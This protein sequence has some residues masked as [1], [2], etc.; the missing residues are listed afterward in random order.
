M[1]PTKDNQEAADEYRR[2]VRNGTSCFKSFIKN[3][4]FLFKFGAIN[5]GHTI[6]VKLDYYVPLTRCAARSDD[7][8]LRLPLS[9]KPGYS[10]N[11]GENIPNSAQS[12][13]GCKLTVELSSNFDR[14]IDLR[15]GQLFVRNNDQEF[16]LECEVELFINLKFIPK[17]ESIWNSNTV[18]DIT[19]DAIMFQL[20][21]EVLSRTSNL[22]N[23]VAI[24]LDRKVKV[25]YE[26]MACE[27][28][29]VIDMTISMSKLAKKQICKA[30]VA[31]LRRLLEIENDFIVKIVCLGQTMNMTKDWGQ[32][33]KFDAKL[34]EEAEVWLEEKMVLNYGR[35]AELDTILRHLYQ[36][37][38]APL[39]SVP[40]PRQVILMTNSA[41][42]NYDEELQTVRNGR[43]ADIFHNRT[44]AIGVDKNVSMVCL[45]SRSD[46]LISL[47][48][49][50][51][52]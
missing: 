33:R 37:E 14:V 40:L 12:R 49:L 50:G 36:T 23:K 10:L 24:V 8:V 34:L 46:L 16:V 7:F 9:F 25:K 1:K 44:W 6:K 35:Y 52:L 45:S 15:A 27:I 19:T 39:L 29:F 30:L 13:D 28:Q 21:Q 4:M 38:R 41:P 47:I 42:L 48:I 5:S 20:D 3:D 43:S 26:L 32:N 31:Q 18:S 17:F 22:Y 11:P 51:P 2:H